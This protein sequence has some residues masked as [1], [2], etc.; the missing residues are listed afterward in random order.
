MKTDGDLRAVMETMFRSPEFFSEGAWEARVKSP[1]EMAASTIR[2][3]G[4]EVTDAWSTVQK[5]SRHGRGAVRKDGADRLPRR[6]GNLAGRDGRDRAHEFRRGRGLRAICPAS[7]WTCRDG[8]AWTTLRL[9]RRFWGARLRSRPWR[10]SPTGWRVRTLRPRWSLRWCWVRRISKGG[11]RAM[12]TQT[13]FSSR[14]G[15][16]DGRDGAGADVAGPRRGVGRQEAKDAGR[17][18]HARRGRWLEHRSRRSAIRGTARCGPI[19]G[20]QPP[21]PQDDNQN[22]GPFG[23]RR[24]ISTASSVCMPGLR[25]FKELWDKK[26][27]AIVEATGS[28]D[29]SR[30]H[31]D[32]QDYME[33]GTPGKTGNGWLNR[34]LGRCRDR[35]RRRCGRWRFRTGCRERCAASMRPSRWAMCRISI[36]PIRNGWR[37]CATCIR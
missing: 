36:F 31:F 9:R 4:A 33:S 18:L 27:L 10:Q 29:P 37:F 28:P 13:N 3:M 16:C 35:M 12:F 6:R 30:S 8:R 15:D 19:L 25:P 7:P 21:R 14:L 22:N 17:D 5:S 34:A 2:A 23:S 20:L 24:S 26:L 32:A 11:R 1:L